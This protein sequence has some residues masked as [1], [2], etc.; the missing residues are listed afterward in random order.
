MTGVHP[1]PE[2]VR[3]F[4]EGAVPAVPAR[5]MEVLGLGGIGDPPVGSGPP[6]SWAVAAPAACP[7]EVPRDLAG[8]GLLQL[9]E[10]LRRPAGDR[11]TAFRLLSADAL[12]TWAC[13]AA[14]GSPDPRAVLD[15]VLDRI[16]ERA[17]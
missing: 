4:L 8:A 5:V 11:S 15:Q 14:A 17:P 7:G 10:A 12:L 1:L 16:V 6:A 3:T 9:E 2:G 13:E